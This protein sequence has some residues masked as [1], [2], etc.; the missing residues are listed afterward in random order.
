MER[1]IR[2]VGPAREACRALSFDAARSPDHT[3]ADEQR[4][5]VYLSMGQLDLL[6]PAFAPVPR[7]MLLHLLLNR[8]RSSLRRSHRSASSITPPLVNPLERETGYTQEE[9]YLLERDIR[10]MRE[11][12]FALMDPVVA[13]DRLTTAWLGRELLS[14]TPE[15]KGADQK[16]R[17]EV[18]GNSTLRNWQKRGFLTNERWNHPAPHLSAALLIMRRAD[19]E[20]ASHWLPVDIDPGRP[21]GTPPQAPPLL[22]WQQEP[23]PAKG[24]PPPDP[25]PCP[26]PLPAGL[27]RA[28]LLASAWAGVTWNPGERWQR[29]NGL[30]AV[31]WAGATGT[32]W[33]VALE[34]LIKWMREAEAFV[35]PGRRMPPDRLQQLAD[36]VLDHVGHNLLSLRR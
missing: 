2:P 28:T 11:E 16:L 22:C 10:A 34:D 13:Q 1:I 9:W 15:R 5:G 18:I 29:V 8:R 32:G 14:A 7:S 31:R 33:D 35:E 36:L 21:P 27:G 6:L 12:V 17:P 25:T 26:I 24:A 4:R 19:T 23:P 20:R 30:G 3:V